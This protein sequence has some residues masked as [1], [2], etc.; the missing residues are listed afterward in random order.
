MLTALLLVA[1]LTQSINATWTRANGGPRIWSDL[2]QPQLDTA[3]VCLRK[4]GLDHRAV[5]DK[6]KWTVLH[7][8]GFTWEDRH[9][10]EI[11]HKQPRELGGG[12]VIGNLQVQCCI[13][14][15][16]ITGE[17]HDKD[18]IENRLHRLV[19]DGTIPLEEAQNAMRRD[20]RAAGVKYVTHS[21]KAKK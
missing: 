6:M 8:A 18:V 15:G 20:W 1:L 21:A 14:K 12:D 3:D 5:T 16:R 7:D 2:A 13:V 11:D 4:W 19:C 9:T 10:H 17:A